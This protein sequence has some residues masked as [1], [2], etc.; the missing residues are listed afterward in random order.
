MNTEARDYWFTVLESELAQGATAIDA[1]VKATEDTAEVFKFCRVRG[2]TC[3]TCGNECGA[4]GIV[5]ECRSN[6]N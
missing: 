3:R 5:T 6:P 1:I 4:D 2:R